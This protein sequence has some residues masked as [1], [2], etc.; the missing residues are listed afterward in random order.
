MAGDEQFLS[1]DL[2]DALDGKPPRDSVWQG[3][4]G[5]AALESGQGSINMPLLRLAIKLRAGNAAEQAEAIAGW[6]EVFAF[7]QKQWMGSELGSRI[8][9]VWHMLAVASVLDWAQKNSGPDAADAADLGALATRVAPLLVVP[10]EARRGAR[11]PAAFG[12]HAERRPR[13]Q[14]RGPRMDV[15]PRHRRPDRPLGG[16]GE[17]AQPGSAPAV[18]LQRRPGLERDAP[19][20]RRADPGGPG[21]AHPDPELRSDRALPHPQDRR[22]DRGLDPAQPE[23][24][25]HPR[26]RR[27]LD[28]DELRLAPQG[29]RQPHPAEVRD[30]RLPPRGGEAGLR[31]ELPGASGDRPPPRQGPGRHHPA[32]RHPRRP[33]AAGRSDSDAADAAADRLAGPHRTDTDAPPSQ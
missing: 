26:G 20:E 10:A 27:G 18:D 3:P 22:G 1:W 28:S 17:I 9:G 12:R 2:V 21:P 33:R 4:N 5:L 25:H 31:L 14:R 30:H 6:K 7:F 15:R 29:R 8:Y 13:A 32:P 23:R 19:V 24:Q 11:R 16:S